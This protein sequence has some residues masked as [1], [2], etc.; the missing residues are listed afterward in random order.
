[1]T[2]AIPEQRRDRFQHLDR[3]AEHARWECG[4]GE[5]ILGRARTGSPG[6]E[7]HVRERLS[8][9]VLARD[10]DAPDV[11]GAL[12]HDAA[13]KRLAE[14]AREHVGQEMTDDV[15]GGHGGGTPGV[16]YGP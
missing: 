15:T 14:S 5:P 3:G 16:E 6:R 11:R 4:G 7:E 13:R 2:G 10:L 9:H 8:P 12:R 1:M